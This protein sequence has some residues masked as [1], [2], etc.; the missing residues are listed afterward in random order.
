MESVCL[1]PDPLVVE[2]DELDELEELEGVVELPVVDGM[3]V[4]AL[5]ELDELELDVFEAVVL[6][7]VLAMKSR[8][9]VMH[10]TY[11]G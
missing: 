4:V 7:S 10:A 1:N 3:V 2:V 9:P 11:L 8:S 6:G 5:D